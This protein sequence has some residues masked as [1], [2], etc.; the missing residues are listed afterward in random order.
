V[1]IYETFANGQQ[2]VGQPS[3]AEFLL[4][5]GELLAAFA[6]LRIVAFEDG[7]LEDPPRFVQR[8]AATSEHTPS[9]GNPQ[10]PPRHALTAA[11][12]PAAP[13]G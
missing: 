9:A 12:G 13:A 5:P 3:R 7:F 1:L 10:T 8:I 6:G 2:T 11:G 4:R